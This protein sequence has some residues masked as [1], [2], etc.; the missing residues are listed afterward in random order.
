[1]SLKRRFYSSYYM[2]RIALV[3]KKFKS[4]KE[5]YKIHNSDKLKVESILLGES[6]SF[7]NLGNNDSFN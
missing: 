6:P 1:M 5:Y 2:K 7:K 3:S 4:F